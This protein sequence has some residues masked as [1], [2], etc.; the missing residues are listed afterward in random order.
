MRKPSCGW[1]SSTGRSKPRP[2]GRPAAD[3]LYRAISAYETLAQQQR[4]SAEQR[5]RLGAL[6]RWNNDPSTAL[7]IHEPLLAELAPDVPLHGLVLADL[8]WDRIQWVS[9]E[10]RY[11][12]PW[13]KQAANE[14]AQAASVAKRQEHRLIADYALV[15]F[16]ALSVPRN[17][18]AFETAMNRAK[19]DL[20]KIPGTKG[21][22]G[23]LVA[24]DLVKGLTAE[25]ETVVLPGPSRSNE[26]VDVAVHADAP[27]QDILWQWNFDRDVPK[28]LPAGFVALTHGSTE[29]PDWHVMSDRDAPSAGQS[30][31]QARPCPI[32]D[33]AH[34]LVANE[35]RTTY[36]DVT[37]QVQ[38][39][40]E[41]GQGEAG[42][43]LAVIDDRNYYAVTLQPSTG[44]VTTRRVSD[45]VTTVLGQ[46]SVKLAARS[47][48]SVRVQRVN[49]LHV[50]KGRLGVFIDG[51]QVAAVDD[52]VLPREGRVGLITMGR[53]TAK[54]DGLHVVELVSNRPLSGPAAY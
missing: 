45:G 18:E 22:L 36:P 11:D 31:V 42:V 30:V 10:R 37:V 48:H 33:C 32:Q 26:V 41:D 1:R 54:F 50:D 28:R 19:E 23:H 40:S 47:W 12:H 13:L 53:T 39:I 9:W 16:E 38:D 6:H 2:G 35:L 34:L 24:N 51:A 44:L 46:V 3:H 8:A 14:A 43:A 7:T 4:A 15:V 17:A 49:F 20:A 5:R 29:P 21:V 27:H 25:G 52:T